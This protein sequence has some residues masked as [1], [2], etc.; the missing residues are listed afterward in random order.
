[1]IRRDGPP[2]ILE[3]SQ[4]PEHRLPRWCSVDKL[5]SGAHPEPAGVRWEGR[6]TQQQTQPLPSGAPKQSGQGLGTW[7][8]PAGGGHLPPASAS[9]QGTSATLEGSCLGR[10]LHSR[11][12]IPLQG[13]ALPL[14]FPRVM[15]R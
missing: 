14:S 15:C 1:M 8:A 13:W 4:P 5:S 3:P 12:E 6:Q 2:T 7:G 9:L 11:E 10:C